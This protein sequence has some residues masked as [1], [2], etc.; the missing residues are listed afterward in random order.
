[1]FSQNN[2]ST[3]PISQRTCTEQEFMSALGDG[4]TKL[5]RIF[6]DEPT[7]IVRH[8]NPHVI[9]RC[10]VIAAAHGLHATRTSTGKETLVTGFDH[11]VLPNRPV[12]VALEKPTTY[13]KG[14]GVE[15]LD[16]GHDLCVPCFD[17]QRDTDWDH[18]DEE[19]Q[20]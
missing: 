12:L 5:S 9:D 19:A 8:Q 11:D 1:M 15:M 3:I 4:V 14:C 10:R 6:G 17:Y 16:D 2:H 13:C 20:S 7:V 18:D